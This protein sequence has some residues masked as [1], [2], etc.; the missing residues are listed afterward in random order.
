MISLCNRTC[1]STWTSSPSILIDNFLQTVT[2]WSFR[3]KVCS[4]LVLPSIDFSSAVSTLTVEWECTPLAIFRRLGSL[5][6]G[7]R[8][9]RYWTTASVSFQSRACLA[10]AHII[11]RLPS[12]EV[13][14][15]CVP[16][17]PGLLEHGLALAAA[18][19]GV[20]APSSLDL[21]LARS[22]FSP[23]SAR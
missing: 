9:C 23:V 3:L 17:L 4:S 15:M 5:S 22:C 14:P 7:F 8:C 10:F 18:T 6:N 11:V 1:G 13:S 20:V 19:T 12:V 2:T 16:V 21:V